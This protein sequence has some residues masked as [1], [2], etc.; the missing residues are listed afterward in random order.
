MKK[1]FDI[2]LMEEVKIFIQSLDPKMQKK[3]V[4]NLQKAREVNDAR[5]FKKLTHEIWEFRIRYE[6]TNIRLLAFWDTHTKA[7]V[8]CATGFIKKSQKTPNSEIAKAIEIR[9]K[10][11]NPGK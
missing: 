11:L 1:K 6:N 5:L 4:F 10:Y 8:I 3:V 7:L 9:K 2:K